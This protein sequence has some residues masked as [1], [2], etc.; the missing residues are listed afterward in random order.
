MDSSA[1]LLLTVTMI[2]LPGGSVIY[3]SLFLVPVFLMRLTEEDGRGWKLMAL[4][5]VAWFMLFCPLQ[6]PF[7]FSSV[8]IPLA[9]VA[10]LLLG[11]VGLAHHPAPEP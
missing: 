4:E 10:M 7:S 1:L 8:N 6:V 11:A 5:G 3:N 2:V 9:A